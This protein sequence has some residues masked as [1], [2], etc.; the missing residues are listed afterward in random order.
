MLPQVPAQQVV[1]AA[2]AKVATGAYTL[3]CYCTGHQIPPL[4]YMYTHITSPLPLINS[5]P[6]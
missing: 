5:L 6:A 2:S 4:I 3:R 1:E